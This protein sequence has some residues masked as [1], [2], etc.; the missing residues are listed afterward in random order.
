VSHGSLCGVMHRPFLPAVQSASFVHLAPERSVQID[1]SIG[2]SLPRSVGHACAT[3]RCSFGIR[4]APH[5]PPLAVAPAS[6]LGSCT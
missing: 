2:S 1:M 6:A 5:A 3:A 4:T